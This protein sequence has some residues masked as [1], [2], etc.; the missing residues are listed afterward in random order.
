[1]RD[2]KRLSRTCRRIR[3]GDAVKLIKELMME[4]LE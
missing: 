1:M 4:D 3:E 2:A